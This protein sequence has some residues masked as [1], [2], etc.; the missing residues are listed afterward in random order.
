L[1]AERAQRIERQLESWGRLLHE[2]ALPGAAVAEVLQSWA[3]IGS[4]TARRFSVE[5][6]SSPDTGMPDEEAQARRE[7][8]TWLLGLPW[9]LLHDG[10]NFLFQGALP[11]RVRRRLPNERPV[12]VPVLATPIRVLL[13]SPRP[14]DDACGYIDHRASAGPMVEAMEALAGQVELRLLTPP[15]LPALREELDRGRDEGRPYHV[16]HFDGHGVYDRRV[17]LGA[18]CFEHEEDGRLAHSPRRHALVSTPELGTL[19][20]DHGIALVFLEACQSAQAEGASESVANALLKTGVSSVAAMSHSVLVETARRFVEAFYRALSDG[21]RIGSAM[22]AGQRALKDSPVR[23]RLLGS[24]EFTLQDW[25]V[26]VLFQDRDDPQL[27]SRTPATLTAEVFRERLQNR[28]GELPEPPAQGFVGRSRELLEL[29]RLLAVE[30][31]AVLRGQGGEGKTAL[32]AEFARWRVR[33]RQ[34]KRA[35]FV[36]VESH[37]HVQAVLDV[38]GHQL[39]GKDYSVATHASLGAAIEPVL[40]ELREQPTLLVIDNL[41]SVLATPFAVALPDEDGADLDDALAADDRERA[42]EILALAARLMTCGDTRI[43]FTSR[44]ALPAPFDGKVQRIELARLSRVDAVQLVERTLGLDAAGRDRAAEAQRADIEALVEAVHGHARTLSLLAPALRERG[45]AATQADLVSLMAEME[46][47][48]PGQR[49]QSLLASVELSLRR[50]TPEMRERAKV[51]GVFHGAVDLEMLRAMTGWEQAEVQT[52]GEALVATGLATPERYNHLS[53]NPAL[54]PYL[55]AGLQ[56]PKREVLEA[57]WTQAMRMYTAFLRLQ[58]GEKSE[59]AAALTVMEQTNLMALL[60][61]VETTGNAG[62]V[63]DLATQLHDLLRHLSRPRLLARIAEVRDAATRA[64]CEERWGHAQFE[65]ERTRLSHLLGQGHFGDAL[66]AGHRL[67]GRALAVSDSAYESSKYDKAMAC[68]LLGR[69]LWFAGRAEDALPQFEEAQRRFEED[70]ATR[71]GCGAAS[72]AA[73][74]FTEQGGCQLTLGR[75]HEA[76]QVYEKALALYEKRHDERSV[77]V[78]IFQMAFVCLRRRQ[79]S[80]SL[81]AYAEARDRFAALGEPL[82]VGGSWH[83]IGVVHCEAGNG[84]AAED[85]YRKSLA[86]RVQINDVAGQAGTLVAL[87]NLYHG[88]LGRSEDAV[89]HLRQAAEQFAVLRDSRSEAAARC[90]LA[91]AL[92]HLGR[93]ADARRE[94]ERAIECIRGLG[95]AVEPW[96]FWGVLADIE[97]DEGR[98][99]EARRAYREAREAYFAYRR[100]GGEARRPTAPLVAK[101]GTLLAAGDAAAAN[102]VLQRA[103]PGWLPPLVEGLQGLIAGQRDLSI[104]DIPGLQYQDAAELLLLLESLKAAAR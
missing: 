32:A 16:L 94:I 102:A 6:D 78:C 31:Y 19:L 90:N 57:R 62:E 85:A 48:F 44:E 33:A 79:F 53:L 96:R 67:H 66:E 80:E 81:A 8:G 93:L 91:A 60:D 27:F 73:A 14:E 95:D 15:T 45:A 72:M 55:A 30:R 68:L 10:R 29:E 28:L 99:T 5:V 40:R 13:V 2:T 39:V 54:C 11:V 77:A 70:E 100:D 59:M 56:S 43:V 82:M 35:A 64:L 18:L 52:L 46:R 36:S 20:R 88:D 103:P 22:L 26:P 86:L 21:K 1:L 9:E 63:I 42:D 92:R 89:I 71:P 74:A 3:A 23:G 25:F 50:L 76:T 51:L 101:I 37:G 65:A 38:I 4:S 47:R 58:Q 83:Q 17:G 7:A 87:G 61:Q 97:R 41:E 104:A 34:V 98:P 24:G 49:E 84:E 12:P 69:A 75:L